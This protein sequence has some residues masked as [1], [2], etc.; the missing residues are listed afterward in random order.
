MAQT[1][2]AMAATGMYVGYST[3]GVTYTE[4]SG[5]SNS[6][7]VSG[8]ERT[9]GTAFTFDGD[10]PIL[11][12]GKRGPITVTVRGVYTPDADELYAVAKTAYEAGS[13]FYFRWSPGG[14]DAGDLGYTTGAGIIKNAPY[15][16][17]EVDSGDPILIEVQLECATV[18]AATI[19]TAGW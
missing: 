6:V 14:G 18:T 8:G 1:T 13:A 3:A 16:G 2:G 17:G 7:E 19:G 10:T 4:C 5:S 12:A 9:T 15:P 11:K